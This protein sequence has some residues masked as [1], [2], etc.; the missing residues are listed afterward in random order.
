VSLL[1]YYCVQVFELKQWPPELVDM[2]QWGVRESV[3]AV[4]LFIRVGSVTETQHGFHREM[5]KLEAPSPNAVRRWVRPW[6]EEGLLHVKATWSAVLCLHTREHCPC[7]GIHRPQ[8]KTVCMYARSSGRHIWRVHGASCIVTRIFYTD[9][10]LCM[11][12]LIRTKR[13]ACN[14]VVSFTEYWLK[15]AEQPSD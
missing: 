7:I 6:C 4:E 9:C 10:E 12:W 5:N 8:S 2:E 14:F 13:Y 1:W 15:I 3:H 11:L